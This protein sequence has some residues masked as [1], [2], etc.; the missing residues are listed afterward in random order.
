MHEYKYILMNIGFHST[1]I[2]I[3]IH[4]IVVTNGTVGTVKNWRLELPNRLR[5]V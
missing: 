5:L 2:Q 1:A 3:M 4:F